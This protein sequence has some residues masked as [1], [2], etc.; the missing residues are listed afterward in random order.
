[1]NNPKWLLVGLQCT[2]VIR[3]ENQFVTI[4][5][6]DEGQSSCHLWFNLVTLR[7]KRR[8]L[9]SFV[10]RLSTAPS[11]SLAKPHKK[12]KPV[13]A[14]RGECPSSWAS[15]FVFHKP[16]SYIKYP[17][18]P[19][20]SQ[21]NFQNSGCLSL[22]FLCESKLP[23]WVNS[24]CW[25]HMPHSSIS[26]SRSSDRILNITDYYLHA[27]RGKFVMISYY[28]CWRVAIAELHL[29]KTQNFAIVWCY[30][31]TSELSYEERTSLATMK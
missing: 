21:N 17:W 16:K 22:E 3:W 11:T 19:W 4:V 24:I 23:R 14:Y 6:L 20:V 18:I 28:V 15:D 13:P 8:F 12:K 30:G 2:K 1:M 10:S 27:Y 5:Q 31:F 9:G 29:I 26:K 25:A 7:L